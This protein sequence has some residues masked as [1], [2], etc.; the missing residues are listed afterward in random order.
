MKISIQT[1]LLIISIIISSGIFISSV[2]N[3]HKTNTIILDQTIIKESLK[4]EKELI[5]N[6]VYEF[7]TQEK[8]ELLKETGQLDENKL[9]MIKHKPPIN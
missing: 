7:I 9:Y 2:L 4:T 3:L 5:R 8:Y 6:I 1:V